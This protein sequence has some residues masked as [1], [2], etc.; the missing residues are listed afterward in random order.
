[1]DFDNS[2]TIKTS[3]MPNSDSEVYNAEMFLSNITK[4]IEIAE[5]RMLIDCTSITVK[6]YLDEEEAY[7]I[8]FE[9]TAS[10][11]LFAENTGKEKIIIEDDEDKSDITDEFFDAE[12][13]MLEFGLDMQEYV[14]VIMINSWL[15]EA[16]L[17][18]IT[19]KTPDS[20]LSIEQK[21][22]IINGVI[23]NFT[24]EDPVMLT[25]EEINK[26]L[27][28]FGFNFDANGDIND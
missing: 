11:L 1:M 18:N 23:A 17:P 9:F 8:W 25:D 5:R 22:C 2:M 12:D 10:G 16:G 21:R 28:N 3:W 20:E 13:A 7:K 4:A 15:T 14:L 27:K 24:E 6:S 19:L 26:A